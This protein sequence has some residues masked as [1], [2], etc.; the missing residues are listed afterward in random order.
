MPRDGDGRLVVVVAPLADHNTASGRRDIG[1]NDK[2]LRQ[3]VL[4][5]VDGSRNLHTDLR[6]MMFLPGRADRARD[7]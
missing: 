3:H 5:E 6:R 4:S 1:G 2:S 7:R